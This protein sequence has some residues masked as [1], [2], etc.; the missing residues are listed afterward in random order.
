MFLSLRGKARWA[1][2]GDLNIVLTTDDARPKDYEIVQHVLHPDYKP[3]SR[4][5]D[6]ALFRLKT[7]VEFSAYIKPICLNTDPLLTPPKQTALATGWGRT[8]L[9]MSPI[10]LYLLY[11]IYDH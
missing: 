4:Y 9:G 10:I 2:V 8:S 3:P 5:N 7:N 11:G 6:I 1:R